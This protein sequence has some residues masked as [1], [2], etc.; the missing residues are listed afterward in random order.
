[1]K[2][3]F[4]NMLRYCRE[5]ALNNNRSWFHENHRQYEEAKADFTELVEMTKFTVA[6]HCDDTL[7]ERVM[8]ARPKDML[9][10]IPRDVRVHRNKP[11]YNPTWRAYINGD[12]RMLLPLG[13]YMMIAPDGRSEFGTGAWC[14]DGEY[15][16]RVRDYIAENWEELDDI[17]EAGGFELIGEKLKR[18]PRDYDPEHPAVEY[19]KHKDW[20]VLVNFDDSELTS[21]DAFTGRVAAEVERM[22]PLR[23]Y[24]DRALRATKE[25]LWDRL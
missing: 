19:L 17:V 24:F 23:R 1:M 4:E 13:Y 21:F 2:N 25:S 7:R 15:L 14:P 11:P 3:E 9:Y 16:R 20:F 18:C 5:L 6:E 12:K 8:F 10:R 22:E